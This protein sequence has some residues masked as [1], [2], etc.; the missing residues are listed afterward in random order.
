ME[1]KIKQLSKEDTEE[2]FN[3]V[4]EQFKQLYGFM[5]TKGLVMSLV[6]GGAQLWINSIKSTL[7]KLSNIYLAYDNNKIV[8]FAAG[9]IRLSPA[10]LGN[11]KIGYYSH[12]FILPDYRRTGT[13]D[14]LSKA[15]EAWFIEKKVDIIEL[16]I[17][18]DNNNSFKFFD[19]LG[20][21][22]DIIKL[23]KHAKVQQ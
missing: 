9:I 8:G 19:K 5:E 20:Y 4:K 15:V 17:I 22:K 23:T 7:G 14:S 18:V 10:Y 21:R 12:L 11:K 13:G 2:V 1:I 3:T 16:E 6:E